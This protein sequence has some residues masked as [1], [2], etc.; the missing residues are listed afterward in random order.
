MTVLLTALFFHSVFIANHDWSATSQTSRLFTGACD[1]AARRNT[2]LH[3]AINIA[4]SAILASSNFFMQ[5][6]VAPTRHEVDKAHARGRWLEIGVQSWHNVR[7]IPVL[8]SALWLLLALSTI[9]LHLIFNS[10]VIER[11][12]FTHYGFTMIT[13]AWIT[14]YTN[15]I[16]I[17]VPGCDAFP[18]G[19]NALSRNS[20]LS[21]RGQISPS[22]CEALNG[23]GNK[24]TE[25]LRRIRYYFKGWESLSLQDCYTRYNARDTAFT[26]YRHGVLLISNQ[27]ESLGE[28]KG[29]SIAE[30][31]N[32]PAPSV[33]P[34]L[35]HV[36][37]PIWYFDIF[38][39]TEGTMPREMR[40][41]Y[42]DQRITIDLSTGMFYPKNKSHD[43]DQVQYSL[44]NDFHRMKAHYCL[45]EPHHVDCK[46]DID[47][48]LLGAVCLIC[49]IKSIICCT[50]LMKHMERDP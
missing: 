26:N 4:S 48:Q 1:E 39:A 23:C 8:N 41:G 42:L 21:S 16:P 14:E 38:D 35:A 17:F 32:D 3:L 19:C 7:F 47:N 46:I 37:S 45:S 5:V 28:T 24:A 34:Q 12:A 15:H 29:W 27:N 43:H 36:R 40:E 13:E 9:P 18:N 31:Y 6:L 25:D 10:S 11:N 2:F 49:F 30:V 22:G 50:I 44:K 33:M 20:T